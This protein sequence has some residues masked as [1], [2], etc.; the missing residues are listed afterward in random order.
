MS[1]QFLTILLGVSFRKRHYE[2]Q[3]IDVAISFTGKND[4]ILTSQK[5]VSIFAI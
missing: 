4:L 3:I 5:S 2:G 1:Q